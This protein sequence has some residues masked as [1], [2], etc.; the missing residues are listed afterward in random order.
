MPAYFL[1][2]TVHARQGRHAEAIAD[3][4]EVIRLDP[5]FVMAYIERAHVAATQGNSVAAAAD[6]AEAIG[7]DPQN[8]LCTPA[9]VWSIN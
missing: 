2:G 9:W 1:R 8:A 7:L 5:A 4:T 3:F 6:L